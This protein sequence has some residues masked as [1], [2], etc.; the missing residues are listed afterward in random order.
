[1]NIQWGRGITGAMAGVILAGGLGSALAQERAVERGEVRQERRAGA[2]GVNRITTILKSDVVLKGGDAAGTIVDF[3]VNDHGCIEYLVAEDQDEMYLIPY[4]AATVRYDDRQVVLAIAP[5]QFRTVTR[6]T[7]S[8]WPDLSNT[9][10]QQQIFKFWGVKSVRPGNATFEERTSGK[11]AV[12]GDRPRTGP[13]EEGPGTREPAPK[14]REPAPRPGETTPKPR[15]PAPR[16]GDTTPKPREPAPQPGDPK[17]NPPRNPNQ[18]APKETAPREPAPKT[19]GTVPIPREKPP[20]E[21]KQ[22]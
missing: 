18:P 16:S 12:P 21:P 1:M 4:S 5:Q 11:P 22:P 19:P 15:E 14:P 6:F 2:H 8:N 10:Y 7:S 9:G 13:R 17:V 3:V 20:V